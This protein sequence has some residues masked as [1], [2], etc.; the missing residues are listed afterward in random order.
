MRARLRECDANRP[1]SSSPDNDH[2]G[3]SWIIRPR[4]KRRQ[5]A[6]ESGHWQGRR[7]LVAT[8][9]DRDHA[10][11]ACE[12]TGLVTLEPGAQAAWRTRTNGQ[13]LIGTA[14]YGWAFDLIVADVGLSPMSAPW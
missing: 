2:F 14:G 5:F 3:A 9:R 8:R 11:A 4:E 10:D 7:Q 1:E 6:A 12:S 13:T